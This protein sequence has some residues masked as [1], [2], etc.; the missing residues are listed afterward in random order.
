L[1]FKEILDN[2]RTKNILLIILDFLLILG[3]FFLGVNAMIWTKN[4]IEALKKNACEICISQ[5]QKIPFNKSII[6]PT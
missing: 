6:I 3:I 5:Q 4:Q 1:S 2:P